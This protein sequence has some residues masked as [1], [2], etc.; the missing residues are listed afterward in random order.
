LKN[1][2]TIIGNG[3]ILRRTDKLFIALNIIIMKLTP[4]SS[5]NILSKPTGP[6]EL[7]TILAIEAAARTI[8]TT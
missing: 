2:G 7:F 5:T 3:D 4:I 6:K 1:G 8:Y